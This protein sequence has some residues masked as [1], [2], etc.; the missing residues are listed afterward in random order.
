METRSNLDENMGDYWSCRQPLVVF[1]KYGFSHYLRD[2]FDCPDAVMRYLCVM[3]H[4]YN[5]PVGSAETKNLVKRVIRENPQMTM[6]YTESHQ[7]GTSDVTPGR[8]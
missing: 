3:Y 1:R 2:M 4:V 8:H 6:F 7:V 5:T